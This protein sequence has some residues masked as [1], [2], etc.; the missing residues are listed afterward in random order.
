LCC[1]TRS[2]ADARPA[3]RSRG[4]CTFGGSFSGSSSTTNVGR[5]Q[6]TSR[7]D[8][9][10]ASRTTATALCGGLPR[11]RATGSIVAERQRSTSRDAPTPRS[12]ISPS[13]SACT[14][15]RH[16]SASFSSYEADGTSYSVGMRAAP[17]APSRG[18][19]CISEGVL[20]PPE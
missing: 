14:H 12:P 9:T 5:R 16:S 6:R 10:L 3:T 13:C 20:K 4:A 17:R 8:R 7:M 18:Q 1:A 15:A 19:K 11:R 2:T